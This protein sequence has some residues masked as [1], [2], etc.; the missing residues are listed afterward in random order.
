MKRGRSRIQRWSSLRWSRRTLRTPTVT[1]AAAGA[2]LVVFYRGGVVA[3]ASSYVA[4][5][6]T[7]EFE[8]APVIAQAHVASV[9]EDVELDDSAIR[10]SAQDRITRDSMSIDLSFGTPRL[11]IA[12][13]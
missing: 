9:I 6:E 12:R 1:I 4:R 13:Q 5:N 7:D 11:V 3:Y 10:T 2:Y 8:S